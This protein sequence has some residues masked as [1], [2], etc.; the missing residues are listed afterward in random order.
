VRRAATLSDLPPPPPE[1][2][3]QRATYWQYRSVWE[4]AARTP[5]R[6][7]R[8][9]PQRI[10]AAWHRLASDQQRSQ[11]RRNLAR[12]VP[13][14]RGRELDRLVRDAYV[15]Y[16]RYWL[17][18]FRLHT[19]DAAAVVAA[20]RDEN[21]HHI[22]R[23]RDSGRGGILATGHLGSWDVGALFTA[24]RDWGMVVVAELVEP[25]RL[26]ER[27]VRL[28]EHAGIGVIPLVRG[29]DMLDQLELRVREDGALATLLADRDLGRRGPIVEFFGEPCRLPPG[30][31]ALARR[32]GRPVAVGAF[33]TDGDGYAGV[34]SG[35]IDLSDQPIDVGTQRVASELEALIRRAPEQWHVFVPNWLADRE[36][37]H[38]VV[39]AWRDGEDWRQAAREDWARRRGRSERRA[40]K[41]N[42]ERTGAAETGPA[43]GTEGDR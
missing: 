36:P 4:L 42:G 19:M 22:D 15:S 20:A 7:A 23:F 6:L 25:R 21:L 3:T 39:A 41:A 30:T 40:A 31:A 18:S 33:L 16:A 12:V 28:R 5:E 24:Q 27:F 34:A 17:D 2:W 29:G 38:P 32:T 10:G 14:L 35:P 9:L 8:R 43:S 11:V 37:G 13:D 1:T 26:F